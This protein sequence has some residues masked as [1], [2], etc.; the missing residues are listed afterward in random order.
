MILEKVGARPQEASLEAEEATFSRG[1]RGEGGESPH[2]GATDGG[3]EGVSHRGEG[4]RG[5][6]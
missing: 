1:G 2:V 5:A 6:G 3:G 4:A